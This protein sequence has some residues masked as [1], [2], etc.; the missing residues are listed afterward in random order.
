MDQSLIRDEV[1]EKL[2]FYVYRLIDPRNGETFYVG[3]GRGSRVLQHA[4]DALKTSDRS[5]KLDR[6]REIID[7]DLEVG[8][9]I[10]RHGIEDEKVAMEV[11]AA[12][13]ECFPASHNVAK[14]RHSVGRGCAHL[15]Q[16]VER[17]AAEEFVVERPLLLI[18]VGK[19]DP[20]G[21]KS[22]YDQVRGCW[23]LT[24]KHARRASL[25]L[26]HQRG[27]VKAAFMPVRWVPATVE[28]FPW[29][30]H[31]DPGRI[32][33]IG[34]E[35]APEVADLYLRKRVPAVFRQKGAANPV[36]FLAP[37]PAGRD[38]TPPPPPE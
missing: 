26:G 5:D 31:D 23:A 19:Y 6:I 20:R 24:E 34:H 14:G 2:G 18:S 27:L 3:K 37:S 9:I 35:A 4:R 1:A 38:V 32:G 8:H 29:L 7:A 17:Y 11:E 12:V 22:L 36:R 16:L 13:M 25:V 33:F 30:E 15:D 28:N 21:E 10:H